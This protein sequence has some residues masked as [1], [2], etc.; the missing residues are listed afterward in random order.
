MLTWRTGQ[1]IRKVKWQRC[2]AGKRVVE[3]IMKRSKIQVFINDDLVLCYTITIYCRGRLY[4]CYDCG[5][6]KIMIEGKSRPLRN[7]YI[8]RPA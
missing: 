1:Q 5:H 2:R 8:S 7:L 6:N 4:V 3:I